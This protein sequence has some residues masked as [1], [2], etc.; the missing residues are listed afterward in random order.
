MVITELDYFTSRKTGLHLN[1]PPE[2][3][4]GEDSAPGS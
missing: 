4:V 3:G 2:G 1:P